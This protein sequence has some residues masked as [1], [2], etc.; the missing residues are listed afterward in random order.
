MN[1]NMDLMGFVLPREATHM[2]I[3]DTTL[4]KFKILFVCC[5]TQNLK[6]KNLQAFEIE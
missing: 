6:T 3:I 1:L 4:P 2:A 5:I